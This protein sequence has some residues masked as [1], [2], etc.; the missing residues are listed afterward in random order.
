MH[1]CTINVISFK[2]YVSKCIFPFL[3]FYGIPSLKRSV[4]FMIL[5][6]AARST[7]S[8]S[9]GNKSSE[10]DSEYH[11]FNAEADVS[12]ESSNAASSFCLCILNLYERNQ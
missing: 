2:V 1:F 6:E 9:S 11:D 7:E 5:N 12:Q 8:K 4:N 10:S 3:S